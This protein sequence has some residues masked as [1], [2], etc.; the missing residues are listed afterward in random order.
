[1][2]EN[3]I[4]TFERVEDKYALT[5]LQAEEFLR[6]CKDHITKDVYFQYTVRSIYYDNENSELVIHS[7]MKPQ[8]KM[9]LRLRCY[10]EPSE[11]KPVFL[12]TKKK[13]KDIV[14]KRR[15]ELGLEEAN[16][17]LEYGIPHHVHNNTADEIDYI[18]NYYNLV[19]KVYIA[20]DRTCYASVD[21]MDVRITFD[22]NIRYR[23]ENVS[24]EEDGT[25]ETLNEGVVMMEVKAMDRY[26]VWL[27]EILSD[28]K[29]YKR[30]FSKFGEI[31][32]A[33]H[34]SM[35]PSVPMHYTSIKN[36][37]EELLCST[38]S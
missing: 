13:Y 34:A 30:S 29:L 7:L 2:S 3:Y 37:K 35:T 1:M 31:Y 11:E 20:Y 15:I 27:T 8:Y 21:E 22:T 17:Y 16:D 4:E 12:E 38:P 18:L 24:L 19:G 23:T 33:H 26:P 6:R 36:S 32:T 9:K 10:G 25:E 5:P 28:M 14:Y